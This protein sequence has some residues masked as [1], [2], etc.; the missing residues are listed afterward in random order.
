MVNEEETA[1]PPREKGG[2]PGGALEAAE[3]Q[4]LRGAEE[5]AGEESVGESGRV[6]FPAHA[7]GFG[8]A[9]HQSTRYSGFTAVRVQ[10]EQMVVR[11]PGWASRGE[12]GGRIGRAGRGWVVGSRLLGASSETREDSRTS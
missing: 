12:C 6:A 11:I 3:K 9:G 8:C 10:K 7:G 5:T 4:L 2:H 1:S